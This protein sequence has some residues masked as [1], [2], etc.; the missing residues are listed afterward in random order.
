MT[1]HPWLG[2][3]RGGFGMTIKIHPRKKRT[4]KSRQTSVDIPDANS[5]QPIKRSLEQNEQIIRELF[6]HCSDLVIRHVVLNDGARMLIVYLDGMVEG[7][8]LEDSV[9]KPLMYRPLPDSVT[10]I[11]DLVEKQSIAVSSVKT[12]HTLDQFVNGVLSAEAGIL[13]EDVAEG[14]LADLK[15]FQTRSVEEAQTEPAIRGPRDGFTE[16]IR[17][18]TTLLRRRIRSNRLKFEALSIGTMAPTDVLITYTEGI[19]PENLLEE[20]RKRLQHVRIDCVVESQYIEEYLEDKPYSPFPQIQDTERPDIVA[21]SLLEGK[22]AIL[23]DNTPFAL[24]MPLTFWSGLQSRADYYERFVYADFLRFVRSIFYLISLLLPSLYVALTTFH[25]KLLP[26]GLLISIAA[27]RE[28]VPFPALIE[29]L[30]MELTFEALREAGIRMPRAVGSAVNIVGALVIGQA[31]VQAGIVSAPMVIVV[32]ATGIANFLIPRHSIGTAIRLVRFLLLFLAGFLGLYGIAIGLTGLLIHVVNLRSFGV[33]YFTPLAPLAKKDL[34]DFLF[35]APRWKMDHD[36]TN[37]V[38]RS[39][40]RNPPDQSTGSGQTSGSGTGQTSKTGD[41]SG[42]E[43]PP[44]NG[45]D[46]GTGSEPIAGPP[47]ESG[48]REGSS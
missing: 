1:V 8:A 6:K 20:V 2:E 47:D 29:A 41:N 17:I 34:A 9:I 7:K 40:E 35:R 10:S 16:S 24:I 43:K 23:V 39:Y 5:H 4:A 44:Q 22:V 36:E 48:Q 46:P 30:I 3:Q 37:M 15:G 27:A 25:P 19:A 18:N 32:A 12:V 45:H 31:A 38:N 14:L 28:A 13:V 21:S 11:R 33:P 42:S 26:T